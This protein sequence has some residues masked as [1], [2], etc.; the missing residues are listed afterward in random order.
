MSIADSSL[1]SGPPRDMPQKI[2]NA[3]FFQLFN[4]GAFAILMG[5]PMVLY[6]MSFN[7]GSLSTTILGM[8]ACMAPLSVLLQI[9]AARFVE[10]LGYRNFLIKGWLV[11][12]FFLLGV[13]ISA[14]LPETI[15]VSTRTILVLFFLLGFNLSRGISLC[16]YM[17]WMTQLI[18]RERRGEFVSKDQM[19]G[20]LSSLVGMLF[21]LGYLKLRPSGYGDLFF[22]AA[23]STVLA[24]LFLRKIPDASVELEIK[25]SEPVP[26]KQMFAFRPFQTLVFL[27][28]CFLT[29]WAGG[30]CLPLG[31]RTLFGVT[32]N[33][34]LWISIFTAAGSF[35]SM[36]FVGK[37][38]E[39]SGSKPILFAG[40]LLQ[41]LHF[42][43]W[44]LTF[45]QIIPFGWPVLAFQIITW[46]ISAPMITVA[47]V[48]LLMAIIPPKGRSHFFAIFSFCCGLTSGVMPLTWGLFSDLLK[49]LHWFI[50]GFEMNRYS[51]VYF[52][53]SSLMI[54]AVVILGRVPE[55]RAMSNEA[56]LRGLFVETPARAFSKLFPKRTIGL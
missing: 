12:C 42:A 21:C 10:S 24:V 43:V 35:L 51:L 3:Y 4:S 47:N 30:V 25:L 55:P 40:C 1:Y 18:P 46:G 50:S 32:D 15:D 52:F 44:G 39:K 38:V 22:V 11:R 9:P 8:L 53:M 13:A 2:H 17:P 26:W 41:V 54:V 5:T 56:F 14:F 19:C 23:L 7:G 27:N 31:F 34:F 37:W 29:S 6:L 33:L 45:A 48:R 36:L 20:Q 16:T 28:V 49:E